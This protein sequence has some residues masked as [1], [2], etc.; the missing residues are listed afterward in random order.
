MN[1]K[2]Y[3]ITVMKL[4]WKFYCNLPVGTRS[5]VHVIGFDFEMIE[6]D[7]D[8]FIGRRYELVRAIGVTWVITRVPRRVELSFFP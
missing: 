4:L 6:D 1:G 8:L 2:A 3:P 5:G 7:G